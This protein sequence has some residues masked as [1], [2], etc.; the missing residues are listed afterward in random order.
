MF[1]ITPQERRIVTF[2]VAALLLGC[3]VRLARHLLTPPLPNISIVSPELPRQTGTDAPAPDSTDTGPPERINI[4]TA[5]PGQLQSLSGIGP[6]L[7]RRI[8]EYRRQHGPFSSP[9]DITSVSGIG[10][11]TYL[12]LRDRI[13]ADS[14]GIRGTISEK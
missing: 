1:D 11:K 3:L 13:T 12:R 8:I 14:A 6:H 4:N 2:L 7:A 9:S 10:E 5:D